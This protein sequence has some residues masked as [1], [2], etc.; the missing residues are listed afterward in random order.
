VA[1][2]T[3]AGYGEQAK[4]FLFAGAKD[5]VEIFERLTGLEIVDVP[6]HAKVLGGHYQPEFVS[7]N[8]DHKKLGSADSMVHLGRPMLGVLRWRQMGIVGKDLD[9][10]TG[11]ANA[12]AGLDD[13]LKDRGDR[14]IDKKIQGE[15]DLRMWARLQDKIHRDLLPYLAAAEQQ[16]ADYRRR[17]ADAISRPDEEAQR[18]IEQLEGVVAQQAWLISENDRSLEKAKK[19]YIDALTEHKIAI[20]ENARLAN[21]LDTVRLNSKTAKHQADVAAKDL[22]GLYL[23]TASDLEPNFLLAIRGLAFIFDEIELPDGVGPYLTKDTEARQGHLVLAPRW[24]SL[25]QRFFDAPTSPSA[26]LLI[27]MSALSYEPWERFR[28]LWPVVKAKV[29]AHCTAFTKDGPKPERDVKPANEM[30]R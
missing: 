6:F 25:A 16:Y 12:D 4:E 11:V 19:E 3:R 9:R 5:I 8:A 20:A 10:L 22:D 28:K 2:A 18:K 7:V 23:Q 26:K 13:A 30:L 24:R 21:E 14:A 29:E 27:E 15:L 1:L 17:K